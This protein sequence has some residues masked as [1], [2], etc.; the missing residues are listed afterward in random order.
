M[1][2]GRREFLTKSAA[3]LGSFLPGMEFNQQGW[4]NEQKTATFEPYEWVPLGKT[5]IKVTRVGF[6]TGMRGGGRQ[7]NQTRLGKERFEAL[8][9]AEQER[10]HSIML[11][12]GKCE[13]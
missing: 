6:G 1:K 12:G 5:K 9:K 2:I 4:A 11:I 8:L 3:G 10:P 7:S 13:T